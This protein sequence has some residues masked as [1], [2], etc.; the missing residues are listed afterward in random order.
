ME[1]NDEVLD[2]F[3]YSAQAEERKTSKNVVSQLHPKIWQE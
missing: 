3:E 1:E 2:E